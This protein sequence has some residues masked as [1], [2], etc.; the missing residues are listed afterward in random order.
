MSQILNPHDHKVVTNHTVV[1]NTLKHHVPPVLQPRALEAEPGIDSAFGL[2]ST[3][4]SQ[5][6]HVSRTEDEFQRPDC[7]QNSSDLLY[8][9]EFL[10]DTLD[11]LSSDHH[12]WLTKGVGGLKDLLERNVTAQPGLEGTL[13]VCP[14]NITSAGN[15]FSIDFSTE[16]YQVNGVSQSNLVLLTGIHGKLLLRTTFVVER[17]RLTGKQ[18]HA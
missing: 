6:V 2:A 7:F 12:C 13:P 11:S 16:K 15:T 4:S 14:V 17:T 18:W 3:P 8:V 10:Q 5:L 1:P 9:I